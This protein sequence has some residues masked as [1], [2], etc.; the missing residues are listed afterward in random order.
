MILTI[1]G[2][3]IKFGTVVI[4]IPNQLYAQPFSLS[5]LRK[6][7]SNIAT[8]I[9]SGTLK[10]QIFEH[11]SKTRI[12]KISKEEEDNERSN[13]DKYQSRQPAHML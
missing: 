5:E 10:K 2:A 12:Q 9:K 4:C 1:L 7:F 8:A 6:K 13:L 3:C 11:T